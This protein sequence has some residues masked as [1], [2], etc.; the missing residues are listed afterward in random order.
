MK[1]DAPDQVAKRAWRGI[2]AGRRSVYPGTAERILTLIQTIAPR[3][4]DRALIRQAFAP[5]A[6]MAL[7][8]RRNE[9]EIKS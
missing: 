4:I 5:K 9:S 6:Q 8:F 1:I 2:I 7:Q 3:L